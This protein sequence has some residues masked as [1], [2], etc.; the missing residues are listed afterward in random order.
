MQKMSGTSVWH[1]LAL[2]GAAIVAMVTAATGNAPG[3]R[4]AR[5]GGEAPRHR[6][7]GARLRGRLHGHRGAG[8]GALGVPRQRRLGARSDQFEADRLAFLADLVATGYVT[9]ARADSLATF[10]VREAYRKRVPPAL[11]FGVLLTENRTSSRGRAPT[12]AR[13]G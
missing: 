2:A 12:W 6:G 7:M 11:V 10:A 4:G 9:P 1:R 13:W 8:A 5:A 3:V